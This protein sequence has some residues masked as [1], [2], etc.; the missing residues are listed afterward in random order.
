MRT[1][2]LCLI[3]FLVSILCLQG[4]VAKADEKVEAKPRTTSVPTVSLEEL[5]WLIF[6]LNKDQ[7]EV[8]ADAWCAL[9]QEKVEEIAEANIA[10]LLLKKQ[11]EQQAPVTTETQAV[12]EP[13][14]RDGAKKLEGMENVLEEASLLP[15]G[16]EAE[17]LSRQRT[18]LLEELNLLR[19]QRA[20][21][22]QRAAAVL[23][24]LETKGGEAASRQVYLDA[25]S[26]LHVDLTDVSA[27]RTALYGWLKSPEGGIHWGLNVLKSIVIFAIFLVLSVAIRKVVSRAVRKS[28]RVTSLMGDFVEKIS[29]RVVFLMGLV[30]AISALGVDIGPLLAL[31]GAAGFVVAFALQESLGNFA[32]GI[33]IL[34]YRPFDV[35]DLI[36]VAGVSGKVSS[37]NLVSTRIQTLDNKVL[38]VPNNAVWGGV[39]TN[40]TGSHQR[41]VDLVFGIGYDDDIEKAHSIMEGILAEHPAVLKDPAPNVRVH[42]L[43]D[44]SVNFI[45]RPWV[46]TEDYWDVY[47]DVTRKVK[48]EFDRQGV[49]I[50]FPQRDV[51]VYRHGL[52]SSDSAPSSSQEKP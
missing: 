4:S 22:V 23:A 42:E 15:D 52:E 19:S 40:V 27:T 18:T 30:V 36:D 13:P 24:A 51:H 7:L 14:I 28:R 12:K 41:R 31:V 2:L 39:I 6:P 29:G 3:L 21:L 45:C 46:K 9:V 33:M 37:L 47:W 26:E 25:V 17:E 43:A 5:S 16:G 10:I 20:A 44:S 11:L 1:H 35:G 34:V 49:S 32:S 38:V 8:E 50:P 48:E